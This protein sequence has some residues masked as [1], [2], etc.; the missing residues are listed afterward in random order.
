MEETIEIMF[1]HHNYNQWQS[2]ISS[3]EPKINSNNPLYPL[4]QSLNEL[5]KHVSTLK[6]HNEDD[7]DDY[8]AFIESAESLEVNFYESL[9]KSLKSLKDF[10]LL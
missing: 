9:F 2:M 5:I 10:Q 1:K 6:D 7:D 3:I 8:I 4:L